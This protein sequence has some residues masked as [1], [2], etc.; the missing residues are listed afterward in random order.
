MTKKAAALFAIVVGG[1]NWMLFYY[2]GAIL[3]TINPIFTPEGTGPLV[4]ATYSGIFMG[5][6]TTP[7]VY[8]ALRSLIPVEELEKQRWL[9]RF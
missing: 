2:L 4:F 8:F 1:T 3:V 9:P 5:V 6:F 7:L